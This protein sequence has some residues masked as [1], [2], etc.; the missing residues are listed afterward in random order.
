MR[1]DA[2]TKAK[3]AN[4]SV[5]LAEI[6]T[7]TF[8]SQNGT[9]FPLVVRIGVGST[10]L[11]TGPVVTT[12]ISDFNS[13]VIAKR[14]DEF[15]AP[16]ANLNLNS[17][18]IRSLGAP[19]VN[20]DAATKKYVDDTISQGVSD[21]GVERIS[22]NLQGSAVSEWAFTGWFDDNKYRHYEFHCAGFG[23]QGS[24]A[25]YGVSVGMLWY[26]GSSWVEGSG[27]YGPYIAWWAS[28]TPPMDPVTSTS[29]VQRHNFVIRIDNNHST[30]AKHKRAFVRGSGTVK[31]PLAAAT[32]LATEGSARTSN[33]KTTGTTT[34][35]Y[36]TE[37]GWEIMNYAK[38]FGTGPIK[39][40]K[41]TPRKNSTSTGAESWL[42]L[43]NMSV[44]IY[45]FLK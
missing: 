30:W 20:T 14:L 6:D 25:L 43:G 23:I 7:G 22:A 5:S 32:H 31:R 16:S 28:A 3:I 34:L 26:N 15:A 24:A 29:T 17:K 2:V 44:E 9:S 10:A 12:H 39:G 40:I 36:G 37:C 13:K 33:Q 18:K 19:S 27:K 4:D 35:Y 21:T 45:G 1:D 8:T 11:S 42:L 41:F 38:S